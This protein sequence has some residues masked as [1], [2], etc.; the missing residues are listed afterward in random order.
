[1]APAPKAFLR[2]RLVEVAVPDLKEAD[3][4]EVRRGQAPAALE[5]LEDAVREHVAQGLFGVVLG[6]QYLVGVERELLELEA[7]G[8]EDL[9][10]DL[11]LLETPFTSLCHGSVQRPAK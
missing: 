5:V 3:L 9:V 10:G 11:V 7:H 1:M 6:A 2:A 4:L 8:V